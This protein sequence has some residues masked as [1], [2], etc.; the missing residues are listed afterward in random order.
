[1]AAVGVASIATPASVQA[2]PALQNAVLTDQGVYVRQRARVAAP[3]SNVEG[4]EAGP[5][6]FSL[7]ASYS[8]E[9]N[10]N[11]NASEGDREGDLIQVPRVDVGVSARISERS[12]LA[13]QAGLGYRAYWHN[14]DL[15]GLTIAPGSALSYDLQVRNVFVTLFDR[16]SYT[17]DVSAVADLADVPQFPRFENTIGAQATWLPGDFLV[18]GGYSYE[19]YQSTSDDFS[20]VNSVSHLPFLRGGYVFGGGAA[21]AGVE[22]TTTLTDYESRTNSDSTIVSLGPYLEWQVSDFLHAGLHGGILY[23]VNSLTILPE[24]SF[25]AD[26][27]YMRLDADH[28][29]TGHLSHR[30]QLDHRVRNSVEQGASFTEETQ[31]NYQIAWAVTEPVSLR[32]QLNYIHGEQTVAAGVDPSEVYDQ[33]RGGAGI[34]WSLSARLSSDL[35]YE[36]IVRESDQPN[37]GYNQNRVTLGLSYRF[38]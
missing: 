16:F 25:S 9:F 37:R 4:V 28:T 26:S 13:F 33:W 15:S 2:Q 24:E 12:E 22:F 3:F 23:L 35:A 30:L 19:V 18:T 17:E 10:D 21:N 32:I 27:Y 7:A 36:Y 20:Y 6:R 34:S 1:V 38:E 8:L 29:L 5:V 31:A 11:V 14:T